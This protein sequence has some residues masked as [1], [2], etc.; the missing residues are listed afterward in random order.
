ML[1][2]TASNNTIDT[3]IYRVAQ[4]VEPLFDWSHI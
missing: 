1:L 4:K 3:M 2:K